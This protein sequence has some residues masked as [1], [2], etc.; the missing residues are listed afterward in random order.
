MHCQFE[1]YNIV[2]LMSL[3]IKQYDTAI[4]EVERHPRPLIGHNLTPESPIFPDSLHNQHRM[5]L[6]LIIYSSQTGA[7]IA[8][9]RQSDQFR[10]IAELC[11][12]A[13]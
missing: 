1:V 6:H 5:T 4:I 3:F 11:F 2:L 8:I 7:I 9:E 13:T 12:L 10:R